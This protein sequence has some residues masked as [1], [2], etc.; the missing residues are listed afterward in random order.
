VILVLDNEVDPDLRYLG[1]ELVRA[2]PDAEYHVYPEDPVNPPVAELDG[3]VFSGSTA[4]VYDDD[5]ADWVRPQ[6]ELLEDCIDEDVPVL[7]VCFGHQLVNHALGGTVRAD[8]FRGGFVELTDVDGSSDVLAGIDPVVPV[9]HGDVVAEPGDGMGRIASTAYSDYFCTRHE[10][11]RV[12]TVQFHPELTPVIA[13]QIDEFRSEDH[14]FEATN[15][16]VVLDNFAAVC[17]GS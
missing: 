14:T 7:G 17:G 4:S 6:A 13:A 3:I 10:S 2:L 1:P 5:H 16:R 9:L 15:A 11:A 12:W 8:E